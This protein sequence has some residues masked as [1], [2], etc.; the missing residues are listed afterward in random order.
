MHCYGHRNPD[1]ASTCI[2]CELVSH[3]RGARD[4]PHLGH[5]R[6]ENDCTAAPEPTESSRYDADQ[7]SN[8]VQAAIQAPV[9][10]K[11]FM[12]ALRTP[13]A[14]LRTL[15]STNGQH[16]KQAV[17]YHLMKF[18]RL[19]CLPENIT[20]SLLH[21]NTGQPV[22]TAYSERPAWLSGAA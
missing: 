15:A 12:A 5:S 8:I 21:R 13:G 20:R 9:S 19:A 18:A 17:H 6:L 10:F 11:V 2:S 14:S 1:D 16:S 3:C 4:I 22:S 7:L